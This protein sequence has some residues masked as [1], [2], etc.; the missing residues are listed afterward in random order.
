MT[1]NAEAAAK[2]KLGSRLR[3]ALSYDEGAAYL[4]VND[5][6]INNVSKISGKKIAYLDYDKAQSKM[7]QKVGAQGVGSATTNA[8]VSA[9]IL[10]LA[11]NYILT[12]LLLPG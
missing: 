5:R 1:A 11:A 8:V 2:P 12:K 9:S 4:F 10:I 7:I 6:S 3:G